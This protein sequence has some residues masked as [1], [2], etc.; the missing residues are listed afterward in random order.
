MSCDGIRSCASYYAG[1]LYDTF[2]GSVES[3]ADQSAAGCGS[4]PEETQNNSN[5]AVLHQ[6]NVAIIIRNH[7]DLDNNVS[8]P[9]C[10]ISELQNSN[11]Q[12]FYLEAAD[13][14]LAQY[15]PVSEA[16]PLNAGQRELARTWL[17][18]K[19]AG[20]R[21]DEYTGADTNLDERLAQAQDGLSRTTDRNNPVALFRT[22]M[23][24]INTY[25][26]N[27]DNSLSRTVHF[28]D[29]ELNITSQDIQTIIDTAREVESTEC[30]TT[31]TP[32]FGIEGLY[33]I[34]AQGAMTPLTS[35]RIGAP[36]VEAQLRGTSVNWLADGTTNLPNTLAFNFGDGITVAR[37]ANAPVLIDNG[38]GLFSCVIPVTLTV[39]ASSPVAAG[40]R[41]FVVQLTRGDT[42]TVLGQ[43]SMSFAIEAALPTRP[44]APAQT[45]D[46]SFGGFGNE[47]GI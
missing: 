35:L 34:N 28:P 29:I 21:I 32:Q 11:P 39:T 26:S 1:L 25:C 22:N 45:A 40:S 18:I 10:H 30:S 6:E 13:Q 37:S 20:Y 38:D 41:N 5:N 24:Q 7:L 31:P 33:T 16:H 4:T 14:L 36:A 44:A 2:L 46:D 12:A 23:E 42:P 8:A 17:A 43:R 3:S 15:A 27:R 47:G 19:L 9:E